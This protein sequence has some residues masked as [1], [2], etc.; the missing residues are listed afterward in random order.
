MLSFRSIRSIRFALLSPALSIGQ[1][2]TYFLRLV[3]LRI[4]RILRARAKTA[5]SANSA[6]S[7]RP[8][9]TPASFNANTL[10][11]IGRAALG[12][13]RTPPAARHLR[14]SAAG[15]RCAQDYRCWVWNPHGRSKVLAIKDLRSLIARLLAFVE[16]S[17]SLLQSRTLAVGWASSKKSGGTP[18]FFNVGSPPCA[19]RKPTGGGCIDRRS[20]CSPDVFARRR[21]S[22]MR[23][24]LFGRFLGSFAWRSAR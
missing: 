8:G 6:N 16:S 10:G 22:K 5:N 21:L 3:N 1:I 20:D 17:S 12:L 11:G 24:G 23:E 14:T 2:T 4:W 13:A 18:F 15:A 19:Q 7:Y 9:H